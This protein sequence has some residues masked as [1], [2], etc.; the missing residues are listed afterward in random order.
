MGEIAISD[1]VG[2][3]SKALNLK[4]E[5]A[6][7]LEAKLKAEIGIVYDINKWFRVPDYLE[8]IRNCMIC[9]IWPRVI[10]AIH[11]T[12]DLIERYGFEVE[13]DVGPGETYKET[14]DLR[15]TDTMCMCPWAVFFCGV[16]GKVLLTNVVNRFANLKSEW[17]NKKPF[18]NFPMP[19]SP[20][21]KFYVEIPK[22][23][24]EVTF[25]GKSAL[26]AETYSNFYAEYDSMKRTKGIKLVEWHYDVIARRFIEVTMP[27]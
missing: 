19:D 17:K 6:E 8:D 25:T 10:I 13:A 27:E 18:I 4:A 7:A 5:Q 2:G 23:T 16:G 22:E 14:V 1:L 15:G 11:D 12:T 26:P 21:E 20:I 9:Q 24:V 3:I